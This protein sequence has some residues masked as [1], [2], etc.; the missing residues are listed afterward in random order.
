MTTAPTVTPEKI[1][2]REPGRGR[3]AT[4]PAQIPMTGWLDVGKRVVSQV[5]QDHVALVA[6]GVAFYG[7]LAIFPAITALIAITGLLY[8]PTEL[9]TA[10]EGITAV[11]PGDVATL[12]MDQARSVAGSQ[13]SGLTLG[14][15]LGLGLALWS[16]SAGVGSLIEGVSLAYEEKDE[17]GFIVRKAVTILMTLG[18]IFGVMVAA[19]LIVVVPVTL[20]VLAFAPWV[21]VVIRWVS[22][23]PL[24]LIVMV[25]LGVLYRYG[26]HRSNARWVWLTP[27]AVIATILWLTASIGFSV[28]VT[29]FASYNETFGS[30]AGVVVLLMWMWISAFVILLGAEFNS[31]V[32]AQTARDTTTGPREPMG[33]RGAVK[34]DHIGDAQ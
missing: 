25:G 5:G 15:V 21:E 31:E 26:P 2:A 18:M 1:I 14:L 9:V 33:Y 19:M 32:E 12:L 23:I 28:Y 17:R 34:A 8:E 13:E 3:D 6:A 27:G 29:N 24:A 10:L 4:V 20:G 11:V 22:Y 7:L 16:A 30:V